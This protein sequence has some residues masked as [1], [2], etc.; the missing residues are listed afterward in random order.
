MLD[1]KC[2]QEVKDNLPKTIKFQMNRLKAV[3]S[4]SGGKGEPEIDGTV[5]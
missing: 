2:I 1:T 4:A 5:L 3:A